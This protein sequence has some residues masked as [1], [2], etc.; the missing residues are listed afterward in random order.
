MNPMSSSNVCYRLSRKHCATT[1]SSDSMCRSNLCSFLLRH[2]QK[3][4]ILTFSD[5]KYSILV[6]YANT[7]CPQVPCSPLVPSWFLS[8]SSLSLCG[9][10]QRYSQSKSTS[11]NLCHFDVPHGQFV[12]YT[13]FLMHE[14]PRQ[15]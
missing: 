10:I 9:G 14:I 15:V 4:N 13:S 3:S 2:N 8:V 1:C 12:Q 6:V 7:Q 5:G 11:F